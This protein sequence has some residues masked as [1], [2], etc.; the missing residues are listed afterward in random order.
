MHLEMSRLFADGPQELFAS[1]NI[2]FTC[3]LV[4]VRLSYPSLPS[5]RQ[6][7]SDSERSSFFRFDFVAH[8]LGSR[9]ENG[10]K[11]L[12]CLAFFPSLC[13]FCSLIYYLYSFRSYTCLSSRGLP[14]LRLFSQ[15]LAFL[16]VNH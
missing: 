2:R 3:D 12:R 4:K 11:Y 10:V 6:L 13:H 9:P 16:N 5:P 15:E 8:C 14:L 7:Q 1:F